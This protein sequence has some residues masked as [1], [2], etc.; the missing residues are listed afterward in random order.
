MRQAAAALANPDI[1]QVQLAWTGCITAESA[2]AVALAVVAYRIT[3]LYGVALLGLTRTVPAAVFGPFAAALVD[4]RPRGQVLMLTLATRAAL[5]SAIAFVLA[6][7]LPGHLVFALAAVDAIVYSVWWPT[8]SALLPELATS[9]DEVTTANVATTVIENLG[10]L[11][12]PLLGAVLLGLADPAG[13][14]AFAA[15][16]LVAATI[17][18]RGVARRPRTQPRAAST[19]GASRFFAGF[20]AA[21]GPR[22]PR[23]VIG[24][25]LLQTLGLGML[26]VLIVAVSLDRLALGESGIGVLT[27]AMGAGGLIGAAAS[28]A[29]VGR[30]RLGTSL[31]VALLGWGGAVALIAGPPVV[32]LV[33]VLLALVGVGNAMVDVTALTLLQ[34]TV[35]D[36]VLVRVLGVFEGLWW[37]MLGLGAVV[38]ATAVDRFGISGALLATATIVGAAAL[39][40]G[41][42]LR[43]VD[44]VAGP[45]A[46]ILAGLRA[47]PF[48]APL[49]PAALERLAFSAE[50]RTLTAGEVL[51]ATG[52]PGDRFHVLLEGQVQVQPGP[53]RTRELAAPASFGE[54]A[55]LR[56]GAR[57]ATVVAVTDGRMASVGREQFLEALALDRSAHEAAAHHAARLLE[58]PDGLPPDP[59]PAG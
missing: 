33:L 29:L 9:A 13:V 37:A 6:G 10:L 35:P 46:D 31:G 15:V 39:A 14:F 26:G 12:G 44:Q 47:V 30:R 56:G 52:G 59:V 48:L 19:A 27:S 28:V 16:V 32:P 23:T 7:G 3:G 49:P 53:D 25:Y 51:V 58:P 36:S 54:I 21:F 24:L 20:A 5:M 11:A 1:R 17:S 55:L 34:R 22:H 50:V 40:S 4:G 43:A 2:Q 41:P 45:P 38:G 8:Q 18:I 57:T 42:A